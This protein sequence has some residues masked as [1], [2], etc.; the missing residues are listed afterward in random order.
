[1]S[2]EGW[3]VPGNVILDGLGQG[4][5]SLIE[6]LDSELLGFGRDCQ[7]QEMWSGWSG[8]GAGRFDKVLNGEICASWKD[9]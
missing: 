8:A 9:C 3:P 2:L 4:M 1:M 6:G 7:F 5:V